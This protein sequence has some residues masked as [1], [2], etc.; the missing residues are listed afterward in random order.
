MEKNII[1]GVDLFEKGISEIKNLGSTV[2]KFNSTIDRVVESFIN[3]IE[4]QKL[5][6]LQSASIMALENLKKIK[7]TCDEINNEYSELINLKLYKENLLAEVQEIKKEVSSIGLENKKLINKMKKEILECVN[8]SI[9]NIPQKSESDN[10]SVEYYYE[11]GNL[12]K[13]QKEYD[14]ALKC[15]DKIIEIKIENNETIGKEDYINRAK[16]YELANNLDKALIDYKRAANM[17]N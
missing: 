8:E 14:K 9:T 2:D 5:E 6:D 7:E 17:N 10:K 11:L 4:Q 16:L 12:Y 13:E 1:D 15:Y 3:V